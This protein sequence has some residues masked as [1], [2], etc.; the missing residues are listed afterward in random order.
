MRNIKQTIFYLGSC[1][2]LLRLR[3]GWLCPRHDQHI[4]G[5]ELP[6]WCEWLWCVLWRS[7]KHWS[8]KMEI[9]QHA[10]CNNDN[11]L[12]TRDQPIDLDKLICMSWTSWASWP[13]PIELSLCQASACFGAGWHKTLTASKPQP[14]TAAAVPP[15]NAV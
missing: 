1:Y 12:E 3:A 2:L 4:P 8:L 9:S 11:W 6:A 13:S 5:I 7:S 14:L 15:K 10:I